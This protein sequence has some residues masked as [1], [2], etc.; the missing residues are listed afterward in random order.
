MYIPAAFQETDPSTLRALMERYSFATLVSQSGEGPLAS[1]LP[2]LLESDPEPFGRL[3]GHM[4]RPNPQWQSGAGQRVLVI[5][6]GPHAYV[7]PTWYEAQNVVPTWNYAAVHA[8]GVLRL[9]E[10]RNRLRDIVRRMVDRY[11]ASQVTPWSMQSPEP[12]FIE[13]MLGGIVGF[14]I[15][16][17]RLE[18]K[19]K[20]S[21]NHPRERQEKVIHGLISTGNDDSVQLAAWMRENDR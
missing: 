2:L 14:E 5:F 18:G 3:I 1:H 17:E 12:D 20:L 4:A 15:D 21:Q 7:S 19:W 10:D 11:E 9:V 13:K 8:Y 6:Q 16:I